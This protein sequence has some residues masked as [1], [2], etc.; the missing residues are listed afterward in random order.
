MSGEYMGRH[1]IDGLPAGFAWRPNSNIFNFCI[2]CMHMKKSVPFL[3]LIT[4]ILAGVLIAGCTSP[5]PASEQ[6][7]APNVTAANEGPL[8]P[9]YVAY[10]L[11]PEPV[12]TDDGYALGDVPSPITRPDVKDIPLFGPGVH[13]V[14]TRYDLRDYDKVSPWKIR[15]PSTPAGRLPPTDP[16]SPRFAPMQP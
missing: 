7:L 9:D 3:I 13:A 2:G 5:A 11:K 10:Q 15:I 8:N 14:E 4:F 6:A 12:T 16:S 1:V